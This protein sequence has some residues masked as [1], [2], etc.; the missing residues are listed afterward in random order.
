VSAPSGP[1]PTGEDME[2][3]Q[4]STREIPVVPAAGAVAPA[5]SAPPLPPHPGALPPAPVV[6]PAP[7]APEPAQASATTPGQA[8]VQSPA[9]APALDGP[10]E[11][12]PVDFVPGLPGDRRGA[13]EPAATGPEPTGATT[14]GR[15][16]PDTLE[17]EAPAKPPRI[18]GLQDRATLLGVGLA[19]LALVLLELGLG[20]G[21]GGR[22]LWSLVPLWS[23]FATLAA[24]LALAGFARAGAGVSWRIG[25]GALAGLAVFWL[26]VV[27]PHADTNRGFV[28][29]AALAALGA[30]LWTGPARSR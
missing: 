14:A 9:P 4:P 1:S 30:G 17:A 27:L 29:T 16:W 21:F 3:A 28:L 26:L 25:A 18:R 2:T 5:P 7:P 19:V 23:A 15:S 10:Q 22:S 20:L 11:T 13:P 8:P 24:L 12:G 6:P